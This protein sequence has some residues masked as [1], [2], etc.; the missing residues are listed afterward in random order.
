PTGPPRPPVAAL[1]SVSAAWSRPAS[2]TRSPR[3]WNRSASPRPIPPAPPVMSTVRLDVIVTPSLRWF[4]GPRRCTGDPQTDIVN[5]RRK[6]TAS[7]RLLTGGRNDA[8]Q[9]QHSP[10]PQAGAER[11]GGTSPGLRILEHLGPHGARDR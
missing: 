3:R 5:K 4:L 10:P 9:H 6:K 1:A 8:E 11:P 2:T 7:P